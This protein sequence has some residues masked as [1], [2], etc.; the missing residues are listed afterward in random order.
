MAAG[1]RGRKKPLCMSEQWFVTHHASEQCPFSEGIS[2]PSSQ[3]QAFQPVWLSLHLTHKEQLAL[4]G[5]IPALSGA[6]HTR[7]C[8]KSHAMEQVNHHESD[9]THYGA[10]EHSSVLTSEARNISS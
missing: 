10:P 9:H 1:E 8:H 5:V 6:N 3:L 4:F 7:W 2:A